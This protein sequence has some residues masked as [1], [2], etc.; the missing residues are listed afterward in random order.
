MKEVA[1]ASWIIRKEVQNLLAVSMLKLDLDR[2]E[3][4]AVVL[5]KEIGGGLPVA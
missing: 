4:E 3:A 5:A 1:S 2:G